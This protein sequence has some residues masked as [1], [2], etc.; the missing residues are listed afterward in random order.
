MNLRNPN[1]WK[2]AVVGFAVSSSL[3]LGGCAG[4]SQRVVSDDGPE[5]RTR[6]A[7]ENPGRVSIA[8]L[9]ADD[10]TAR[11]GRVY[12][13]YIRKK[14]PKSPF[15]SDPFLA[16]FAKPQ[17]GAQVT[18]ASADSSQRDGRRDVITADATSDLKR[19][20][21]L[22]AVMRNAGSSVTPAQAE[23]L[24][25][26][27]AQKIRELMFQAEM[28]RQKGDLQQA[29]D[30]ASR[31][32]VLFKQSTIALRPDE[33]SPAELLQRLRRDMQPARSTGPLEGQ[34]PVVT[35]GAAYRNSSQAPEVSASRAFE[36]A[37]I[38]SAARTSAAADTSAGGAGPE[39]FSKLTASDSTTSKPAAVT[40]A[41]AST[42]F[43]RS[44]DSRQA[45]ASSA[46]S[47]TVQTPATDTSATSEEFEVKNVAWT[48]ADWH[49]D[50]PGAVTADHTQITGA[51]D[52][53]VQVKANSAMTIDAA[54]W[55]P[56]SDVE[57]TQKRTCDMPATLAMSESVRRASLGDP[58]G[59]EVPNFAGDAADAVGSLA[60]AE[61]S[62]V[63]LQDVS[64]DQ[65]TVSAD[66]D[67]RR[68]V[69]WGLWVGLGVMCAACVR[70]LLRRSN[71]SSDAV[72]D[73]IA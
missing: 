25:D 35:P 28:A 29:Y 12:S 8:D 48:P 65:E 49:A 53:V 27:V 66:Q 57:S 70:L 21:Q 41:S 58:V 34:L 24:R 18:Q 73:T 60:V 16:E 1:I 3:L 9:S 20:D 63:E 22:R 37:E 59:D 64:L 4:R 17:N 11:S 40:H 31:S 39:G 14:Q 56:R 50:D 55:M 30:L 68:G 19:V 23:Q 6:S 44:S 10:E 26:D 61:S 2:T 33:V 38:P 72:H 62:S 36:A 47:R 45:A 15:V 52:D 71:D 5:S 67:G 69:H 43:S 54:G 7:T 13:A 42:S 51:G 32:D 46:S